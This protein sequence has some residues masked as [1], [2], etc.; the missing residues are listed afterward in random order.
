MTFMSNSV[1]YEFAKKSFE[2]CMEIQSVKP[3]YYHSACTSA[4]SNFLRISLASF[5]YGLIDLFFT[6]SDL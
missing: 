3:S 5:L 2:K 1:S 6:F 4:L